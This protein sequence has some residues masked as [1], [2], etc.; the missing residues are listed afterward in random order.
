MGNVLQGIAFIFVYIDDILV[1]S[2]SAEEHHHRLRQLFERLTAHGLVVNVNKCT[3]G[4]DAIEFLGHHVTAHDIGPLADRVDSIV[5]LPNPADKKGLQ[6]CL[7][8][9]N[10]YHR[11]VPY[12]ANMLRPLHSALK[13]DRKSLDWTDEMDDAFTAAKN[14]LA[15]TTL[16]VH[17]RHGATT[18]IT[19]DYAFN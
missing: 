1:A 12:A 11:F 4:V 8:I 3:F 10:F 9:I 18:S 2:T 5:C 16:L 15:S 7:G 6:E 19:V 14:A 13:G 17:P